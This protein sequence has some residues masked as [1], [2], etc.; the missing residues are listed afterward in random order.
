MTF[1]KAFF[2]THL[3]VGLLAGVVISS[4]AVSGILISYEPQI[5]DWAER[6]RREVPVPGTPRLSL[7][8]IVANAKQ[9]SPKG[10]PGAVS[11]KSDPSAA[12]AVSFGKEGGNLYLDSYSGE[13]LGKDSRTAVFLKQVENWHRWLG[14]RE[15]GKP[16]TGAACL[17]FFFLLLSGLYLWWPR[18]W[19]RAA[20]RAASVPDFNLKGKARD[21]N[22]HNTAGL[23]A[24]PL[25]LITTSTGLIVNYKWANDLLFVLTGNEPP[26]KP[27]EEKAKG[28]GRSKEGKEIREGK[29]AKEGKEGREKPAPAPLASLDTVMAR[30]MAQVPV[31]SSIT[32]RLPQKPG[33]PITAAIIEPGFSRR[34]ARSQLTLDAATAEVKKWE[35][36]A[37]Q[38]LG[39]R[40]R[41]WVVPLHTGRAGG[42]LG[43]FLALLSASA[44]LLLVWTGMAMAWRRFFKPKPAGSK[45]IPRPVGATTGT[46]R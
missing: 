2:W 5:V 45:T 8:A 11:V 6:D 29:E 41:S 39:R 4:M 9:A 12:V 44:A 23:W 24:A 20:L 35:P 14:S 34:Y 18:R 28:E 30:A 7:D 32:L 13:A 37:D 19:T 36:Y 31:W 38:N 15:I 43:Q 40:L 25:L 27:P 33:A 42:P 1:R 3:A 26:P 46:S 10:R 16:I 17:C 21:W 22:W